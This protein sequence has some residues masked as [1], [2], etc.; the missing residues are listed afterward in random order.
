[1]RS[2]DLVR[3]ADLA[4]YAAKAAGRNRVRTFTTDLRYAAERRAVL[5]GELPDAIEQ[6]QL[7]LHYQPIMYLPTGECSGVEAL[8][9]W[10]HPTRGLLMPG[11]WLDAAERQDLVAPLARW[12]LGEAARQ[13]AAWAA[14]GLHLVTGV[15]VSASHFATGTLVDD[16]TTALAAAGLPPEQL[17]IELTETSVAGDPERAAEQFAALRRAGVEVS[18]DD[19]GSGWS[20]ISQLI[21]IPTGVIKIDRALVAGVE[22]RAG[23]AAAAIAAVVGL[24]HACGARTLAEGVE[25]AEQLALAAELGCAFAQGY[26]IARPMTAEQL[27]RWMSVWRRTP[28]LSPARA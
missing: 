24:A 13:T 8:V 1:V 21:N 10:Q 16:V 12:V 9:R 19:F 22:G 27:E 7:L 5:A 2:T 28:H 26:H 4:M 23:S 14:R 6:G 18:L 3:D 15:N 17:L 11:E 25:T 20:S